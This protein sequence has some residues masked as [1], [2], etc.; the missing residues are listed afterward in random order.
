MPRRCGFALLALLASVPV[1]AQENAPRW[2]AGLQA[3]HVQPD[4]S[5]NARNAA[6]AMLFWGKPLGAGISAEANAFGQ[7]FHA[8]GDERNVPAYGGGVDLDFTPL[9]MKGRLF[10][11]LGG[12][13]VYERDDDPGVS[14]FAR[15]GIGFYVPAFYKSLGVVPAYYRNRWLLRADVTYYAVFKDAGA[16]E[17]FAGDV[18]FNIGVVFAQTPPRPIDATPSSPA[19]PEVVPSDRP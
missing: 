8:R 6:G 18:R 17:S 1:A 11:L 2:Y 12:G 16:G 19:D 10:A 9:W 13:A 7:V 4:G 3:S 14:A 15:G 5:R